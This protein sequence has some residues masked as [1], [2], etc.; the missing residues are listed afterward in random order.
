[1]WLC[2]WLYNNIYFIITIFKNAF[3]IKKTC[4]TPTSKNANIVVFLVDKESDNH[5]VERLKDELEWV[6]GLYKNLPSEVDT[7]ELIDY[8]LENKIVLLPRVE[9]D[10]MNFNINDFSGPLDVLLHMVRKHEVDIYEIDLKIIIDEYIDFIDRYG[11][12]AS[13]L[14]RPLS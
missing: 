5:Q 8:S 13:A 4:E 2:F 3:L 12:W 11:R 10:N 6:I 7:N 1:M 9:G 14:P